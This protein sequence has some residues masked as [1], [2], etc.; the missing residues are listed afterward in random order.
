VA[1]VAAPMAVKSSL[2]TD[3][4]SPQPV[5]GIDSF[6]IYIE[7]KIINPHPDSDR[8]MIVTIAFTVRT[9]STLAN[10][11]IIDSPGKEYSDEAKRVLREGPLWEP[12]IKGGKPVNEE[13][14]LS[15][16]FR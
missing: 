7:K 13:Y 14:Q 15:I 9:D 11:R 16:R 12:A 3:H 8:E 5:T 2:K 1:G 10:F 4:S 6:N